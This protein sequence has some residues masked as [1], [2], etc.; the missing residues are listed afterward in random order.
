MGRLISFLAKSKVP[1]DPTLTVDEDTLALSLD[2][3]INNQNNKYLDPRQ[4]EKWK[5]QERNPEYNVPPELKRAAVDAFEKRKQFVGMCARAGVR[6]VA[7]TDGPG[8]GTFLP[9]FGLQHE[10]QLLVQSGLTPLQAI[11]AAT[12]NSAK[13]LGREDKLG[14]ISAGYL[15]DM[16]ILEADPLNNISNLSKIDQVIKNGNIYRPAD[17]LSAKHSPKTPAN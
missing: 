1:L 5:Q 2:D 9:G 10:L 12:I 7:G 17:L 11:Q 6:I 8:L 13:A 16:V 4:L 3:Q 15:A 14:V